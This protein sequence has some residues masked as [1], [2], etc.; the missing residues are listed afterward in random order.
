MQRNK[1]GD[2]CRCP[3]VTID[4]APLL[5]RDMDGIIRFWSK[6]SENL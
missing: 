1:L 6:G 2:A 5:T 3:V 4:L